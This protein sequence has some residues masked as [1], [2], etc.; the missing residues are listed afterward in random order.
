MPKPF[1]P[2]WLREWMKRHQ[3]P[4][5]FILHLIGIPMTVAALVPILLNSTSGM[6]WVYAAMLFLGGYVL[7]FVGHAIEGNDAGELI[8]VKKLLGKPY[9]A[10]APQFSE[11]SYT[12]LPFT[13]QPASPT[14]VIHTP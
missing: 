6:A 11:T 1:G 9:V 7:Q 10:I 4:I 13:E 5:S 14:Q 3:N 8:L 12:E 2:T